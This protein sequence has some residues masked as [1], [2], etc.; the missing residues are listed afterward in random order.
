MFCSQE[1]QNNTNH[2]KI[3]GANLNRMPDRVRYVAESILAGLVAFSTADALSQ[4]VNEI[5][6]KRTEIPAMASDQTSKYGFF[7]SLQPI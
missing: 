2:E 6:Q 3:C 4:F 7:L 5:L 1:C